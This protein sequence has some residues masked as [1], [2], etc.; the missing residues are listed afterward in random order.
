MIGRD[1][2]RRR[3]LVPEVVQTSAMDC[4]PAALKALL[5]GFGIEAD[6]ARLRDA[7]RTDVDGTSISALE[8]LAQQLGL[9]AEQVMLPP[10]HLYLPEFST[11]PALAVVALANGFTHFIVIWR[12]HGPLVQIMDP[13]RG[14]VWLPR[15]RLLAELYRHRLPIAAAAWRD[16]A[17]SDSFVEPLGQRLAQLLVPATERQH[18]LAAAAADPSWRGFAAL[19]AAT[20]LVASLV[21]GGAVGAGREAGRMIAAVVGRELAGG[22]P[23]DRVIPPGFWSVRPDAGEAGSLIFE[24]AVIVSVAGRRETAAAPAAAAVR[25]MLESQHP[26]PER[27]V[28][29]TLGR[30]WP[31]VPMIGAAVGLAAAAGIAEIFVL[32]HLLDTAG[33]AGAALTLASWAAL[34]AVLLAL[35]GAAAAAGRF[36]GRRLETRLRLAL[37]EKLR[38]LGDGWFR[39][40]LVSDLSQRAFELHHLRDLPKLAAG[41]LRTLASLLFAGVG[42]VAVYPDGLPLVAATLAISLGVAVMGQP[43]L[44]QHELR[45]RIYA[46]AL[47]RFYYDALIGLVPLRNHAAEPALRAEQEELVVEWARSGL[48][49]VT[50]R[51]WLSG[52]AFGFGM[53]MAVLLVRDYL[54][55]GLPVSGAI[56]L[57]CLAPLLP[58]TIDALFV[59]ARQYPL[60]R[61]AVLRLIEPLTAPDEDVPGEGDEPGSPES[62][63]PTAAAA[64]SASLGVEIAIA[65]VTVGLGGLTL[66]DRV[67][68]EI[69]AGEHVAIVGP[70]G[71]GKTSLVGLLLGWHRP[72]T[73]TVRVDGR[74]LAGATLADL[75]QATAWVDPQVQL[76]NRSLAANLIFG[77]GLIGAPRLD[78][79]IAEADLEAIEARLG[80]DATP[81]GEAGRLVSGGEAQKVRFGRAMLRP[82]TRLVILDEPFRGLE[83]GSRRKL[84]ARAQRRWD[85]ATLLFITH[86]VEDTATFDRVVVVE[87]GRIVEDGA[88]R[89]LL[90]RASRYRSLWLADR[91]AHTRL[92]NG[93]EWRRLWMKDGRL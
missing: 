7:C 54:A 61:G 11:L 48:R 35:E 90:H 34:V 24:A 19:D 17:G 66:L 43:W 74:R 26:R 27:L 39:S 2:I 62:P 80:L 40:R 71:A 72:S 59:L 32:R 88:P 33:T 37:Y 25:A 73:G 87:N 49:A 83:R 84:L 77:N 53:V 79:V 4:G 36:L 15:R 52:G 22:P 92:W 76:W 8:E 78:A 41:G 86:D 14:R 31:L 18:L 30:D 20:R 44:Q 45:Q 64:G 50:A 46:G 85:W 93:P 16:W 21:G 1:G 56:V 89:D 60:M 82:D 70:S 42:I 75:R 5:D 28:W 9:E 67:S 68:L 55:A 58:M 38:R 47:D 29:T 57:L 13:A 3:W 6:Y 63:A 81:L 23:G 91:D 65:E 12:C 51:V 69:A 10:D